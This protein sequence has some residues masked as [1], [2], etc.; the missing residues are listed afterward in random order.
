MDPEERFEMNEE[1][2][3]DMDSCSFCLHYYMVED[4]TYLPSRDRICDTCLGIKKIISLDNV[5]IDKDILET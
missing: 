2:R 5:G 3:K 4:L 1:A